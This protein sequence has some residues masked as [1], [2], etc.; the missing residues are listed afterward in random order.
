MLYTQAHRAHA[1]RNVERFDWA[2]TEREA[3]LERSA[4]WLARTDEVI[5]SLVTGQRIPRGIH[6]NPELGC[7]VCG[8][9]VYET[10]GNYPWKV[11]LERPWKLECPS[12][13]AVWPG[14]DFAA[15]RESGRGPGGVFDPERADL[16]L[17]FHSQ[18]RDPADPD[19]GL[20]VDD[21]LGW[22]DAEGN[23]WWFVAYYAHYCIWT[24]IPAAVADLS[25]AYLYTGD[26]RC[27]H[28][29]LLLLDR[30]AD[31]YPEMDLEPYSRM[32]L[33]NSHG[34][35]GKGRIKGCIWE[36][37]LATGLAEAWSIVAD[38]LDQDTGLVE[39]LSEQAARWELANP[40]KDPDMIRRNVQDNLLREF[41]GS[42]RDRRIRGNEGM[43]QTAMATA[44][45]ALDDPVETPAAL[46]WLFLPGA[47][48]GE[49]GGHIPA[50]LVGQVDGDGVGNE[51]SPSYS[52]LWM[53]QFRRCA[54]VLER[55]RE[56]RDYDLYRDFPR[57]RKMCGAPYQ[58]TALDR[59]TPHIGDTAQ[60]GSPGMIA[61]EAEIAVDAFR[62]FGEAYFAQ[63]AYRL[64]GGTVAGLH[65]SVLDADPERIQ[66]EIEAVVR[67][68]G[69]LS[70]A[71]ANLN[72]YGL[73]MFRTGNGEHGRAAW[74]YYGRNSGHGHLDRLNFGM[75]YRGMNVLPDL[76]YPEYAD[77]KWPKRAGW[78]T[79]TISH[80]TVVVDSSAQSTDWIG[81]CRYYAASE[82]LGVVEVDSPGVYSQATEYRR[83]LAMIDVDEHDSYLVDIFRV[84]GGHDHVL[85]F[86]AGA[87]EV[88]C[89]GLELQRQQTGTYAGPEVPFG[90]HYDGPPDGRYR[91]SGFAY[92]FDVARAPGAPPGWW[93]DWELADDRRTRVGETPVH[94]RYRVLSDCD[95]AALAAGE[96]PR[97][98][99]GN[100]RRLTYV[101]QR[102]AAP[103]LASRFVSI[104]EPYSD[105]QPLLTQAEE[106]DLG[107]EPHDPAAAAVR[108]S[109]SGG[110][111]DLIFSADDPER[112][113]DLGE[114]VC[115][116]GRFVCVSLHGQ[117]TLSVFAVGASRV[118]LPEG[119]LALAPAAHTAE[120]TDFQRQ[121]DGAAWMTVAG[122]VPADGRLT[123]SWLRVDNDGVRDAC[124]TIH[125]AARQPDG[126]IRLD[127][128]D[129]TLVRGFL[130]DSDY[131]RGFTYNVK[132][133]QRVE[134]QSVVHLRFIAGQPQ[135]VT[136]NADWNL[137]KP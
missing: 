39:F 77:G 25:R 40:K 16:H 79:N 116:A 61:V 89:G 97:N 70:L 46:D 96:P 100:P 56:H 132:R 43:T 69:P 75:Y 120:L 35:S 14:N 81:R 51:A 49:G 122:D 133:G 113:F 85:S 60:T 23:R 10:A 91:G 47:S 48:R 127:L 110:R 30:I 90:T 102:R 73:V 12:C 34:G 59:Y 27:A 22:V 52:F 111:V 7:P 26:R 55:C 71:S 44:A 119:T 74:L 129:T 24:E 45:A 86:H 28:K 92:L 64:N 78:T 88:T 41:I 84:S 115:A 93:V 130:D 125:G 124:Y 33:Y 36:T 53:R 17:L 99:P 21:G 68:H 65:T 9:A 118:E 95:E 106:L 131:S 128:G 76:G 114:G 104:V 15:Y 123:G 54:A 136:A 94:L 134:I 32:G 58:L 4:P 112:C 67:K 63:L 37:G 121:E 66:Q 87:G 83:T 62:R 8:R 137:K 82:G 108:T 6:V 135:V 107:L 13:G 29:A 57:L 103:N 2:R 42:C 31:V 126:S 5:W 80:N 50:V 3:S 72:G 1:Q 38:A 18:H 98:K 117:N 101:L 20:A 105:G 19:H 11:S 109:T